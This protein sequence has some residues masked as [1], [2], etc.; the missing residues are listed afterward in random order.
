MRTDIDDASPAR[1]AAMTSP[2]DAARVAA[3]EAATA[4]ASAEVAADAADRASA[5]AVN[6]PLPPHHHHPIAPKH[7]L[8][9]IGAA[10]VLVLALHWLG[11]VLTPFLIGA[12]LAYLGTPVVNR[13]EARG[14]PRALSTLLVIL[15]IGVLLA[16]LF[17]VLIPLVQSELAQ[18]TRRV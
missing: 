1:V 9:I 3:A 17:L 6:A 10:V 16:A 14:V 5:S 15:F 7:Y 13:A 11:S 18:I 4:A 12:I 8:W 2:A